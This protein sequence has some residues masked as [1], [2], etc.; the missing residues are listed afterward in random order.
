[1]SRK[2][3]LVA[4][5]LLAAI[6]LA[7]MALAPGVLAQTPDAPPPPAATDPSA[8]YE[9]GFLKDMSNHHAQALLMGQKCVK[10][11]THDELQSFCQQMVD[12][13]TAEIGQMVTALANWYGIADY[14]PDPMAPM[15]DMDAMIDTMN[16]MTGTMGTTGSMGDMGKMESPDA[17][18]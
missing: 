11:A 5:F 18:Q 15:S 9:I 10:D 7:P 16:A 4:G 1:M 2:S 12:N 14:K 6:V 17:N 3:V 13:Q 8:D